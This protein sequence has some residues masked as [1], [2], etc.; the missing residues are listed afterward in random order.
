MSTL[1]TRRALLGATLETVYNTFVAPTLTTDAILVETPDF[2]AD[3]TVLTRDFTRSD[4]SPMPHIMGR[5]LAKMSFTTELRGNGAEQAGTAGSVARIVRLFQACGYTLT[6]NAVASASVVY[7]IGSESN[8]I[9]W[10]TGG[11]MTNTD[12]IQYILDV[13][14][15]GVSGTAEI[16]VTSDTVGEGT[17][18]AVVTTAT[19][20]TL[21]TKG[22]T[23]TPAFTGSLVDGQRWVVWLRPTCQVLQPESTN[24]KSLSLALY[25][26]GT[27][28]AISGAYGTF[29]ITADAGNYAKVKWDFTGQY[30]APTDVALPTNAVFETTLPPMVQLARLNVDG[31]V[32]TVS[33]MSF[34]QGNDIQPRPDVNNTDGYNGVRLVSRKPEFGI[35]PEADLVANHD[36]WGR[37]AAA[38]QMPFEMRIGTVVGN[39]VWLMAPNTQYSKMTYKDRQGIRAYDAGLAPARS[40]GDDELFILMA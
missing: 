26:D 12:V 9:A 2:T 18:A 29:S 38:T 14:A 40:S 35:D 32:A 11:S 37:M 5:K 23:V 10:T 31:F 34:T 4:L 20:F 33:S 30:V 7:D 36:F 19:P 27:E 22:L 15:P 3:M 28:H 21:G 39:T 17:A 1:L 16:T 6:S 13:T 24:F 8:E 25:L